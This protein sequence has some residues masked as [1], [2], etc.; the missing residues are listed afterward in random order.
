MGTP[1]RR[2]ARHLLATRARS[3]AALVQDARQHDEDAVVELIKRCERLI[4]A[5]LAAAGLNPAEPL[6]GDARNMALLTI[7]QQFDRFEGS[8][9][10]CPWMYQIARRSAASRTLD[11][12]I[13]ERHRRERHHILTSPDEL[14]AS[15]PENEVADRDLV[16]V[17]LGRLNADDREILLLRVVQGLSTKRTAEV[18]FLSEGG[19]KARLHRAKKAAAAIVRQLEHEQ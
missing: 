3:T 6:Y 7:W 1:Q 15:P 12:E 4:A 10:P 8:G 13:R 16:N 19:V 9:E 2:T 18:L 5:G 14:V 17:V 11:P